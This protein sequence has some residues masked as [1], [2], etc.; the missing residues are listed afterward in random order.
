MPQFASPFVE[1]L[2]LAPQA[3]FN[4]VPNSSGVW[5]TT[6]AKLL[7]A[8]SGCK[9]KADPTLIPNPVKTGTAS[10]QPGI[11]GRMSNNTWSLPS[12]PIIPCGVTLT[13]PDMDLILQ[14]IF[15]Q[16]AVSGLYTL[17]DGAI[18]Q[19]ILA[20]FQHLQATLSQ[21]FAIGCITTDWSI[22][23]NGDII[24]ISTN[25]QNYWTL[26]SENWA[27]DVLDSTAVGGLTAFP[28]EVSSPTVLGTLQQGFKGVATF[29]GNGVDSVSFPLISADVKGKT[30]NSYTNDAFGTSRPAIPSHGRRMVSTR[31]TFQETDAAALQNLKVK[32]KAK[33]PINITYQIGTVAGSI[34]TIPIKGVQLAVP[35]YSDEAARVV[36]AFSDSDA[37]ASTI[38]AVDEVSVAFT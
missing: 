25:G 4:L 38:S 6:N 37:S 34:I 32:A 35:E 8:G 18:I 7:R 11:P 2:F 13:P 23:I 3:A 20:R 12:V 21:Q 17:L 33:T 24:T 29:D 15:G 14:S 1:R 22:N 26:D 10:M 5:T 16:A 30:G 27:V 9:I 28:L 36:T 19:F 31:C